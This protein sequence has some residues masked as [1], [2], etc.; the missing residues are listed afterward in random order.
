MPPLEKQKKNLKK[1]LITKPFGKL[2]DPNH[3]NQVQ[4]SWVRVVY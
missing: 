1:M 2:K 4:T 3:H